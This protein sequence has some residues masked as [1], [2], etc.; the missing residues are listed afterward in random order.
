MVRHKV[1]RQRRNVVGYDGQQDL[2]L[3]LATECRA[4]QRE[5][6]GVPGRRREGGALQPR[7]GA[8][9][10]RE[11]L[12]HQLEAEGRVRGFAGGPPGSV[13]VG[14]AVGSP[15]LGRRCGSA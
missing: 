12:G 10:Q 6:L 9:G 2:P 14:A 15:P 13:P 3:R 5:Q 7:V 11:H 8:R 1:G 4:E